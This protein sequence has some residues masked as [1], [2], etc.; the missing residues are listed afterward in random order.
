MPIGKRLLP[1]AVV[2]LFRYCCRI[3]AHA[4]NSGGWGWAP[5][6]EGAVEAAPHSTAHPVAGGRSMF[7]TEPLIQPDKFTTSNR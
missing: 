4:G 1:K 7:R 6:R 3:P 2:M 5:C